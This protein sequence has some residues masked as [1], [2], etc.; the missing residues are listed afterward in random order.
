MLNAAHLGATAIKKGTPERTKELLR[1]L[2][3]LAA[4]FGC[5]EDLLLSYGVGGARL[6]ARRQR[7]SGADRAR[8]SRRELPAV[9]I[10]RPA[11]VGAVPAGYSRLHQ[12]AGRR[13]RSCCCRSA[14]PIRPSA[15][16]RRP[17]CGRA[18]WSNQ[19]L[20]RRHP[21]H[22][23]RP[24]PF[25]DYDQLVNDW[26]TSGGETDAQG[27]PGR[28]RGGEISRPLS[29]VLGCRVEVADPSVA[30]VSL[31]SDDIHRDQSHTLLSSWRREPEAVAI[32]DAAS[33][34]LRCHPD[35][36]RLRHC[37]RACGES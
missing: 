3:Y 15:S 28:P 30:R 1:V 20:Q 8:Q 29:R 34:S 31:L 18:P 6:H 27:V 2:N 11:A 10:H 23:R 25:S 14:S 17:P 37:H 13:P 9:Q 36:R 22:H 26:Q 16:S 4:P 35:R 5:K 32:A 7:Q 33:H 24:P 12:R 19:T 21:R